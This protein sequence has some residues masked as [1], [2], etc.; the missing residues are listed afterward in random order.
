MFAIDGKILVYRNS[1][2]AVNLSVCVR[3][4]DFRLKYGT[5]RIVSQ[6]TAHV[7]QQVVV[8]FIIAFL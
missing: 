4:G 6:T 2:Q 1:E 5:P 7:S 8:F 3:G